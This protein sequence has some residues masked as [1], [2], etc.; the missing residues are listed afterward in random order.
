[1]IGASHKDTAMNCVTEFLN[2]PIQFDFSFFFNQYHFLQENFSPKESSVKATLNLS[3]RILM[4]LFSICLM[5]E[6]IFTI[7]MTVTE[8]EI[9]GSRSKDECTHRVWDQVNI[10]ISDLPMIGQ[11]QKYVPIISLDVYLLSKWEGN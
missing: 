7:M 6:T 2:L 10:V 9:L 5:P 4:F 3:W 8:L 11:P 1:M